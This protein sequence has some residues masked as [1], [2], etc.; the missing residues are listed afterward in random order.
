MVPRCFFSSKIVLSEHDNAYDGSQVASK[1]HNQTCWCKHGSMIKD[2]KYDFWYVLSSAYED[3][4]ADIDVSKC[5]DTLSGTKE[6]PAN[7]SFWVCC[8]PGAHNHPSVT[9]MT[10]EASDWSAAAILTSDWSRLI[11]PDITAVSASS[12]MSTTA[13]FIKPPPAAAAARFKSSSFLQHSQLNYWSKKII[14]CEE[15][16]LDLGERFKWLR[17][18]IICWVKH[19][20]GLGANVTMLSHECKEKVASIFCHHSN[21]YQGHWM[22]HKLIN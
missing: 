13:A 15:R 16:A 22:G 2:I 20:L 5:K 12:R 11:A 4:S 18:D 8:P 7:E 1:E 17:G 14:S 6:S 19:K 10:Q 3:Q 9:R 21:W